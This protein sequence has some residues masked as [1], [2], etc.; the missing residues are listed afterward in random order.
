MEG[1]RWKEVGWG[2][3][4]VYYVMTLV[5]KSEVFLAL[6][7]HFTLCTCLRDEMLVDSPGSDC[8]T[9]VAENLWSE[10]RA[11]GAES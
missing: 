11:K 7:C 5:E 1:W 8:R 2:R 10:M 6:A 3:Q 4:N 9:S